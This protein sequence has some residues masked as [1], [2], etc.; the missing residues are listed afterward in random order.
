MIAGVLVT[1]GGNDGKL[2]GFDPCSCC[3]IGTLSYH[4]GKSVLLPDGTRR[5]TMI[6]CAVS[7]LMLP[8]SRR[9]LITLCR[10]GTMADWTFSAAE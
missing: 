3:E 1:S 4:R 5:Q 9:K 7:T 8:A 2:I 6:S 10:D